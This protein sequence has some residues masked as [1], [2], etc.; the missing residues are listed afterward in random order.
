MVAG[1]LENSRILTAEPRGE[2]EIQRR[3]RGSEIQFIWEG[4]LESCTADEV[5]SLLGEYKIRSALVRIRGKVTLDFVEDAIFGNAV[6]RPTL[7]IANK[8]DIEWNHGSLELLV[9]IVKPLEVVPI[10]TRETPN[11]AELIGAKLFSILGITRVYT[12]EPGRDASQTP[13]VAQG[14]LTVGELAKM[15]HSDFYE[16]FKYARLWGDGAKFPGE[17][18]GLDRLLTDGDTVE[19]HV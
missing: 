6:H 17:R 1:E 4:E 14:G 7:V 5:V 11:L 19:L 15:I 10:S 12:K 8:T 18:V 9:E 13:I 3:G 2:V 16:R